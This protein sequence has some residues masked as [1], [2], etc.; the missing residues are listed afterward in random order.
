MSD[1]AYEYFYSNVG[2]DAPIIPVGAESFYSNVGRESE[3]PPTGSEYFYSYLPD[4]PALPNGPNWASAADG[5]VEWIPGL[6]WNGSEFKRY[7]IWDGNSW[8]ISA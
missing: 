1:N 2:T 4:V 5:S 3:F 8:Q 7:Q 6:I